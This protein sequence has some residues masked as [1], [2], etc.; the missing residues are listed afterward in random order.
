MNFSFFY[1]FTV[2]FR[3]VFKCNVSKKLHLYV[4]I[5]INGIKGIFPES[6]NYSSSQK[7][8][9]HK[10][11]DLILTN[12]KTGNIRNGEYLRVLS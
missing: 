8:K 11:V 6:C 4:C 9:L 1:N 3:T 12:Y 10:V 5:R 7:M 2:N